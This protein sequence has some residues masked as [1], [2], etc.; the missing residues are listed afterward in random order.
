MRYE[1]E[2]IPP[3]KSFLID[4]LFLD[5]VEEEFTAGYGIADIVGIKY[6]QQRLKSRFD[7]GYKPVA[8]MRELS[9]LTLL[10]KSN[11]STA[12]ALAVTTGLSVS[13]IKKTLLK[14]LI[15][16]GY[17]ARKGN[18]YILV[19][20]VYSFTDLVVSVEAKLTK[21]KDALA[22]AKRYQHFSNIVFVAL[23]RHTVKKINRQLF[24]KNNIGV[25]SVYSDSVS[26]ELKP[27]RMKPK[28][29][30]MHL[31]CNEIFLE[32]QNFSHWVPGD[33]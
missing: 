4:E 9:I 29:L 30:V 17:I 7:S 22:Q 12:E 8:N 28:T 18:E 1:A 19:K 2:M 23:P 6:N 11:S 10:Q 31:Y 25:L 3:L 24:R 20:D 32:K 33:L 14:S 27:Q 16:K 26:I 15:E 21:W 13:Y 5:V